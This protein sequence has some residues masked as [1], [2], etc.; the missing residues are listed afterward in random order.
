MRLPR[1]QERVDIMKRF[2]LFL[3]ALALFCAGCAV[4]GGG[5]ATVGTPGTGTVGCNGSAGV[6]CTLPK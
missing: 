5:D 2:A 3:A 4:K 6:S 1:W